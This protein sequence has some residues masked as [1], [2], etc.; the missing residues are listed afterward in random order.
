VVGEREGNVGRAH[1]ELGRWPARSSFFRLGF[2]FAP[3]FFVRPPS[4][5]FFQAKTVR[6]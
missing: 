1:G 3:R 6:A 2:V 4:F 5:S